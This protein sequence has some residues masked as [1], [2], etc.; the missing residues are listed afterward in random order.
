M[1]PIRVTRRKRV[2]IQEC[3]RI[4]N[5]DELI[6][7]AEG[8]AHYSNISMSTLWNILP[9]LIKLKNMIGMETVKKSIFRQI[10]YYIQGMHERD[11]EG[12]YL[13]TCIMGPPGTGKT[14]IANILGLIYRDLGI[15]GDGTV[16]VIHKDDLIGGYTGQTA[17][18]TKKLLDS[19][20]GGILFLDDAYSLAADSSCEGADAYAKEAGDIITSFLSEHKSDI[21]FIIAGYEH[22]I[23]KHFFPL[24]KGLERRFPW[25]HNIEKYTNLD[26]SKIALKIIDEMQWITTLNAVELSKLIDKNVEYFKNAGGDIET[27]ITKCKIAH[28]DR[29]FTLP[30]EDKFILIMEDFEEGLNIMKEHKIA[31]EDETYKTMFI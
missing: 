30:I 19:A 24:N 7:I 9:H 27:F 20:I 6:A 15:L 22:E 26:L 23:K 3:P 4:N 25:K 21:C 18:K 2:K 17:I 16:T 29:V 5:L 13:N 28:S 12:E 10:I 31:K 1:P 11:T 8:D 14:S